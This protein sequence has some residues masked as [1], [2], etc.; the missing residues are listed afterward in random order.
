MRRHPLQPHILS[1]V[2]EGEQQLPD[3]R[4]GWRPLGTGAAL[5]QRECSPE[6]GANHHR[7]GGLFPRQACHALERR[8]QSEPL[9]PQVLLQYCPAGTRSF[10]TSPEGIVMVAPPPPWVTPSAARRR[11]AQGRRQLALQAGVPQVARS[12]APRRAQRRP[13]RTRRRPAHIVVK[14]VTRGRGPPPPGSRPGGGATPPTA[15][16]SAG[17]PES[18]RCRRAQ[19]ASR[20]RPAET[21]SRRTTSSAAKTSSRW[22][23]ARSQ[24]PPV[25]KWAN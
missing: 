4:A 13:R 19:R 9:R 25:G 15:A 17:W 2:V 21:K 8:L 7:A 14:S 6:V 11:R 16:V 22:R 3:G 18:R 12:A 20:P 10:R 24:A 5:Q 1:P 23:P